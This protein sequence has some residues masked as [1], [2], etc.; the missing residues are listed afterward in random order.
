MRT[1]RFC[2]SAHCEVDIE[3]K[4]LNEARKEVDRVWHRTFVNGMFGECEFIKEVKDK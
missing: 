1:F 3:A 2:I 4:D